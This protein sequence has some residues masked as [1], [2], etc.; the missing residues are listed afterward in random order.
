MAITPLY[1]KSCFLQQI[2]I[3]SSVSGYNT[4][5]YYNKKYIYE[6]NKPIYNILLYNTYCL[7]AIGYN[8]KGS[9]ATLYNYILGKKKNG[10]GSQ[11]TC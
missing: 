5:L 7:K 2:E 10:V 4:K 3:Q 8:M 6:L 11:F 9:F 1:T